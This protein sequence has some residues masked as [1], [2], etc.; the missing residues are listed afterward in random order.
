MDETV[1]TERLGM[2]S[3]EPRGMRLPLRSML[4]REREGVRWVMF[5]LEVG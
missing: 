4:S 3:I 5:G 2:L 1:H